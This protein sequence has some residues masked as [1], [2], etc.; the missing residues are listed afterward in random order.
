[1]GIGRSLLL[2]GSK[3][4]WMKTNVPRY[5][6]VKKAVKRFMPGE[7][8]NDALKAAEGLAKHNI[9]STFTHLG[10]NITTL[11][12][13]KIVTEEY[14]ALLDTIK[15]W[16]ID[17]EISLKLT[18][19]G[20]D[21]S[22]N[23]TIEN[24]NLIA[25]KARQY[26][27]NIFIDIEDNS[28]VDRTIEFYKKA[29]S[30]SDNIG[31]CLQAYLYRTMDDVKNLIDI[32]PWLRLVKGAYNESEEVAFKKKSKVDENYFAIAK[33]LM[34]EQV[35]GRKIRVAYGTHDIDLQNR[36]I[37][38]AIDI[39]LD[40][41]KLEFQMLF[42]I[43]T[44]EQLELAKNGYNIRTLISYGEFWFPWYMRRLAE[45]PANVTFVLKNMFS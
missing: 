32:N 16:N 14:L 39:G 23:Q 26:N 35:K 17:G 33:F 36:I 5:K 13:A 43:K 24:F 18:Q 31:L 44:G 1:M 8:P 2:W 41:G 22:I 30:L 34:N 27:N 25:N 6:F 4:S 20:F 19:L 45:R 3:N 42:G 40:P 10:E 9:P 38:N 12:E 37:A 15:E 7:L 11:E 28:Y 29:K 21:L